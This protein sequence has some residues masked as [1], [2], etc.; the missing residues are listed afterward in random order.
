MATNDT[1]DESL[2]DLLNGI[3]DTPVKETVADPAPEP[4]KAPAKARKTAAPKVEAPVEDAAAQRIRE[5]E[6]KIAAM[7]ADSRPAAAAPVPEKFV[8]T[9]ELSPEQ[10]KIRELEDKLAVSEARKFETSD[11]VYEEPSDGEVIKIHILEDGLTFQ[12]AI[13]YRGQEV[14]FVV[15]GTAYEQTKDR[16]GRSWLELRDDIDAQW[17]RYGK[18]MFASG[19]WR[20]KKWDQVSEFNSE[21]TSEEAIAAARKEAARRNAA[22][23]VRN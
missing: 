19:P 23:I 14:D 1:I 5:L 15:G 9:E 6:A 21:V 3:D 10:K 13:W 8:P 17:T 18:L 7:E 11:D 22:P 20:G 16:N 2:D 4:V 12:G